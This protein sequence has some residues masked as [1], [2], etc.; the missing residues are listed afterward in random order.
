MS[1]KRLKSRGI[2]SISTTIFIIFLTFSLAGTM[3]VYKLSEHF[4]SSALHNIADGIIKRTLTDSTSHI[5]SSLK[6]AI[7]IVDFISAIAPD[8][9]SMPKDRDRMALLMM[10]MLDNQ[11]DVYSIYYA[12]N[13]GEFFLVGKRCRF[14]EKKHKLYFNKVISIKDGKRTISEKWYTADKEPIDEVI[15]NDDLNPRDRPWYKNSVK[16]KKGNWTSPYI[17]Y[18]TKQP[19]MTYSNPIISNGEISGVVGAD[20]EIKSLS[21]N[22]IAKAFTENTEMFIISE[23]KKLLAHSELNRYLDSSASLKDKIPYTSDFGDKVLNRMVDVVESGK[24]YSDYSVIDV[25][26]VRYNTLLQSY[27]VEGGLDVIAG[28]YTPDSD[29][30]STLRSYYSKLFIII[31]AIVIIVCIIGMFVAKSL[32]KPFVKLSDASGI[33]GKLVFD[34]NINIR[35]KF[36][37]VNKTADSFNS[38]LE[39]LDNYK[40]SNEMLSE[41]LHNAHVDTLYRLALA[42]EHKDNYTS[43]HLH[44]VSDISVAIAKLYGLSEHDQEQIRHASAMHDVGKIG[45]PDSILNKP[46]RLT[47]EEYEIVKQHSQLGADILSDPNSEIMSDAH[48]VALNHHERWDGQ[49]YPSGK[50]GADIPLFGRIVAIADVMDALLSKRVYKPA[51]SFEQTIEI[52]KNERGKHFDPEIADIVL[53]NQDIF[54]KYADISE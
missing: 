48:T 39:A 28:I 6:P 10:S 24:H 50:E 41:S 52:I 14:N 16:M 43:Q 21:D 19:G 38:M 20:L 22:M 13:K 46:G 34:K 18:I 12:N 35:S 31:I 25:D 27:S 40:V 29:Y 49:G 51:Y 17:F 36:I 44:R 9:A 47:A 42:A 4:S 8:D 33:A 23:D 7:N 26:G 53:N 32:A 54:I 30:M 15:Q 45:V 3:L 11:Q 5:S 1:E 37:E 2:L